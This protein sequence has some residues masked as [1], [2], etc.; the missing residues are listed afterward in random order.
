MTALEPNS[1]ESCRHAEAPSFI[2]DPHARMVETAALDL[3]EQSLDSL[4]VVEPRAQH[5][6]VFAIVVVKKRG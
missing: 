5:G 6:M 2:K 3:S 4:E 1:A